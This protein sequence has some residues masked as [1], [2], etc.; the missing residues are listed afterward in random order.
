MHKY[1]KF[2]VLYYL[3]FSICLIQSLKNILKCRFYCDDTHCF[4]SFI[5]LY[6]NGD[7][8]YCSKKF[9]E[10]FCKEKLTS[11]VAKK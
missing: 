1:E 3:N 11:G 6:K 7:S 2:K 10:N 9:K 4:L 5:F 8:T